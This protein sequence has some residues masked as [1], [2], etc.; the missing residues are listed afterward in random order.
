MQARANKELVLI[1]AFLVLA[2]GYRLESNTMHRTGTA[3]EKFAALKDNGNDYLIPIEPAKTAHQM[4]AN[5]PQT[6]IEELDLVMVSRNACELKPKGAGN[7]ERLAAGRKMLLNSAVSE[8]LEI[9]SG[10]GHKR[11]EKLIALR[12][13][14]GGF[15][16]LDQL[17][18]FGWFNAR[19]R[20]EAERYFTVQAP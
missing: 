19:M 8:E 6:K 10:I 4:D 5:C 16:S 14:L 12:S 17:Q 9:I 18:E 7:F 13:R 15:Q 11:A 1:A 20:K 2:C 3:A